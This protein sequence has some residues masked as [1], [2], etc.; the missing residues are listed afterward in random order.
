MPIVKW[1]E[2]KFVRYLAGNCDSERMLEAFD[3][4][5]LVRN[6]EEY[7][8]HT[9]KWKIPRNSEGAAS[10]R[11][12]KPPD[13]KG[14]RGLIDIGMLSI[15]GEKWGMLLEAKW[16]NDSRNPKT[17]ADEIIKDI[18]RLAMMR[19]GM[20]K[21]AQRY[22]LIAGSDKHI[23]KLVGTWEEKKSKRSK[24]G[25]V[26]RVGGLENIE[27]ILHLPNSTKWRWWNKKK[28][29]TSEL[30]NSYPELMLGTIKRFEKSLKSE[31]LPE[32]FYIT[33][34]GRANHKIGFTQNDD[35]THVLLWRIVPA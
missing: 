11:E 13:L 19:K 23:K 32:K 12:V 10:I 16:I 5:K 18:Y 34:V 17:W 28:R 33:L 6:I 20:A 4:E 1:S 27:K 2:G 22:M 31:P 26:E 9:T 35:S 21:K 29:E 7:L 25:K 3:E 24:K 14:K 8:L 30:L 15:R